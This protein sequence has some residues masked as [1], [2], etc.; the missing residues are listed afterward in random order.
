MSCLPA[1]CFSQG[2]AKKGRLLSLIGFK[3]VLAS[4]STKESSD[5]VAVLYMS[6]VVFW[7]S[8]VGKILSGKCLEDQ[9]YFHNNAKTFSSQ[10]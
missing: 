4:R 7:G 2:Q 9:N 8:G 3:R 1:S 10:C 5:K 6:S